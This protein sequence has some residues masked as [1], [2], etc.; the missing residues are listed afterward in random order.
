[1]YLTTDPPVGS[2][3]TTLQ[4][5]TRDNNAVNLAAYLSAYSLFVRPLFS[6]SVQFS[7]WELWRYDNEPS[8]RSTYIGVV[9]SPFTGSS[10]NSPVPAAQATFTFRT[11]GGGIARLQ[12]MEHVIP[13]SSSDFL[14]SSNPAVNALVNF[15]AANDTAIVGRDDWPLY[16]PYKESYGQNEA[17]F[18]RRFRAL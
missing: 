17:L 10:S 1:V 11:L 2:D 7:S 14:P 18:R 15:A 13:A 9:G 8:L 3:T 16:V 4:A 5:Q 6:T 12:F